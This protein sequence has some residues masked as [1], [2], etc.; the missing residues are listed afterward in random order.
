MQIFKC[1]HILLQDWEKKIMLSAPVSSEKAFSTKKLSSSWGWIK[2]FHN[3]DFLLKA[4]ILSL[5]TNTFSYFAWQVHLV[6]FQDVCQMTIVCEFFFLIRTC[7]PYKRQLVWHTT[8]RT[9]HV[10][11]FKTIITFCYATERLSAYF[12]CHHTKY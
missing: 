3:S 9:A 7:I 5:A 6:H 11:F 10:I 12:S 8:Q 2:F 1:W 4:Q